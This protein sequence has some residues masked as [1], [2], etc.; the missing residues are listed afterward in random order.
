MLFPTQGHHIDFLGGLAGPAVLLT[1]P[2]VFLREKKQ[3]TNDVLC[4]C[5]PGLISEAYV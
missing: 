1:R 5:E 4:E 3:K 2:T